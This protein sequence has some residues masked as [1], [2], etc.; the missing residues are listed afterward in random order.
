VRKYFYLLYRCDNE[1]VVG[2][3]HNCYTDF[4]IPCC[5]IYGNP[6][7]NNNELKIRNLF[8]FSFEKDKE[9][10]VSTALD[11]SEVVLTL[12]TTKLSEEFIITRN[13][14]N[15]EIKDDLLHL[16]SSDFGVEVKIVAKCLLSYNYN[17]IPLKM[18]SI[19][20]YG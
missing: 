6:Y 7:N 11:T 10:Q 8:G 9:G 2:I 1:Q 3:S 19:Y 17:G 12:N 16:D 15:E 4:H 5:L 14:T 18:L 13:G 20:K